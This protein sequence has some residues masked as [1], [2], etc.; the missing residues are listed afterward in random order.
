LFF[1][2]GADGPD[3]AYDA[4]YNAGEDGL[5]SDYPFRR[6]V[7]AGDVDGNGWEDL[8]VGNEEFDGGGI[9][10]VIGGGPHIPR[11]SLPPSA[12]RDVTIDG[13]SAAVSVWPQPAGDI[14]HIAWRGDLEHTPAR[15]VVHDLA[16]RIVARGEADPRRGEVLWHCGDRPPGLYVVTISD[17]AGRVI[18]RTTLT[19]L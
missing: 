11:D 9:A 3:P 12:I 4:W 5:G 16:G 8:L 14:V 15:F 1:S 10:L 17:E 6:S 18:V 2:G 19:K 13:R 7:P